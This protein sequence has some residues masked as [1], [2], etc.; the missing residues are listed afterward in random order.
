MKH[1]EFRQHRHRLKLTQR[2]MA[3]LLGLH[4]NSL[5]RLERGEMVITESLGRFVRLL[6]NQ[7]Q[8]QS[9]RSLLRI[10][11]DG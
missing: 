2:Q 5:A 6:A 4:W 10:M 9:L 7:A 8:K 11:K 1:L 3:K